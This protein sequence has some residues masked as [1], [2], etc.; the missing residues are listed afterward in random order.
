MTTQPYTRTITYNRDD[1]DFTATVNDVFIGCY[2]THRAAED[3]C[4]AYV[5]D[6]LRQQ[7]EAELTSETFEAAALRVGAALLAA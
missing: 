5:F 6:Q 1:N 4:D 2:P 3:A 7:V